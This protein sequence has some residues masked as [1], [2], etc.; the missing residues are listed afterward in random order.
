MPFITVHI[1]GSRIGNG[2]LNTASTKWNKGQQNKRTNSLL[3]PHGPH[4]Y[5]KNQTGKR[6][7]A[8]QAIVPPF[9]LH[10]QSW[11]VHALR[12]LCHTPF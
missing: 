1:P 10:R 12:T 8:G 3:G 9:L 5:N 6:S 2:R 4:M 7:N 11:R